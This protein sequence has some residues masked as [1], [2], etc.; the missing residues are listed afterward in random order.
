M[1]VQY[2]E[3]TDTLYIVLK[4]DAVAET[5][6]LDENTLMEFDAQGNLVSMTI[7]HARERADLANF[8]FQ[9]VSAVRSVA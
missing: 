8:S 7:E 3:D 6:D 5:R 1:T 4:K 9:Q 2:F